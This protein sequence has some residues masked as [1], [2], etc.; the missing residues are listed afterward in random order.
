MKSDTH[1]AVRAH[2]L[3]WRNCPSA[4]KAQ[5]MDRAVCWKVN[6][7]SN[8]SVCRASRCPGHGVPCTSQFCWGVPR[9]APVAQ[10]RSSTWP[11]PHSS[12]IN[13]PSDFFLPNA[14][15][16]DEQVHGQ[17]CLS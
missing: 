9:V 14:C 17:I 10:G 11:E 13:V 2:S 4:S 8:G 1:T 12:P 16:L 3:A 6:R 15:Y 5:F 7:R